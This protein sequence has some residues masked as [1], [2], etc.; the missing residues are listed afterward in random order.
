MIRCW[1]LLHTTGP[2]L[3]NRH[4]ERTPDL[5]LLKRTT[6]PLDRLPRRPL[7]FYGQLGLLARAGRSV[8]FGFRGRRWLP[9]PVASAPLPAGECGR[10]E[11]PEDSYQT[12]FCLGDEDDAKDK[13]SDACSF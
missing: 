13:K 7:C 2:S 11:Q 6:Y 4:I 5:E 12:G 8:R 3:I 1:C 9:G 10:G